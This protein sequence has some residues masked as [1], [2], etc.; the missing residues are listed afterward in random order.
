MKLEL[1]KR[2]GKVSN[3]G[4]LNTASLFIL[5]SKGLTVNLELLSLDAL[6]PES[7]SHRTQRDEAMW[8]SEEGE[9]EQG[10]RD[11]N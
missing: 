10:G 2:K 6:S 1:S 7:H 3:L 9:A 11:C 5:S 8:S 4:P